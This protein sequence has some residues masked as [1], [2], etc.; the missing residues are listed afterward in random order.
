MGLYGS[1][2][3]VYMFSSLFLAAIIGSES[4]LKSI[5]VDIDKVQVESD[6]EAVRAIKNKE[7][8]YF[9][10]CVYLNQF[11]SCDCGDE[12]A[13]K[14]RNLRKSKYF[15]QFCIVVNCKCTANLSLSA[16]FYL[17]LLK[18]NNMQTYV[19]KSK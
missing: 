3:K 10:N 8:D 17:K 4:N 6:K 12:E 19:N 15:W 18:H 13:V 9:F 14:V 11:T 16:I 1:N 2:L 5:T 7:M